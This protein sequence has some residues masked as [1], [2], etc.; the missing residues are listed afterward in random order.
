MF[1]RAYPVREGTRRFAP[2]IQ[3]ADPK[4]RLVSFVNLV[5]AHVLRA[6]RTQH[7]VPIRSVRKA[8]DYA[9]REMHLDRLLARKELRTE[10]GD[11]L[12]DRYGQLINLSRSGQLAMKK[13]LERYLRRVEWD[14]SDFPLRLYPF[15]R[16]SE[17]SDG[18]AIA[19]DPA[20][21]FGRPIVARRGVE[22]GVIADRVDAGEDPAAIADDYNLD[23]ADIEAAVLYERAA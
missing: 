14:A 3:A 15:V 17:E 7:G 5:E 18:R 2:L 9:E 12:L 21:A 22:T 1:G 19:I 8:L 16:A 4:R 23:L 13:V 11:L 20:I 6:L 10:A